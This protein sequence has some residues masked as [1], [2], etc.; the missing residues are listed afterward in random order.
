MQARTPGARAIKNIFAAGALV[1]VMLGWASLSPANAR[2]FPSRPVRM[3]VPFSAGGGTDLTIRLLTTIL[4][5]ILGQAIVLD[6]MP[7]GGTVIATEATAKASPDGYTMGVVVSSFYINPSIR[8]SLPYN[9]M[10]DFSC[11][12]TIAKSPLV[13]VATPSLKAS[14]LAE[15]IALAKKNPGKLTYASPG[16]GTSANLAMERFKNIAGINILHIPYK[17]GAAAYPDLFSG[18]VSLQMVLLQGQISNIKGGLVKPIAI[19]GAQRSAAFPAIPTFAETFPGFVMTSTIGIVV[20]S[21]TPRDI[22]QKLSADINKALQSPALIER[23]NQVG[24]EPT[25][26]TPEQCNAFIRSEIGNWAKAAKS[27]GLKAH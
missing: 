20:P 17:S 22:V 26:S 27:A 1:L 9:T 3:I 11:V 18:R 25:G 10:K 6:Y 13:L 24:I 4:H 5:K 14:T 7:G 8:S 21:A 23:M 15:L 12:S 19:T 16:S 2:T